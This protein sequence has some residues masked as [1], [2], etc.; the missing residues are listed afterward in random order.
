MRRRSLYDMEKRI[1]FLEAAGKPVEAWTT[2]SMR[3]HQRAVLERL[4]KEERARG[5][6]I[7]R[8]VLVW[9]RRAHCF[10]SF[11]FFIREKEKK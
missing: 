5:E 11:L 4:K 1:A 10:F 3:G 6:A 9:H 8:M 7:K 2:W